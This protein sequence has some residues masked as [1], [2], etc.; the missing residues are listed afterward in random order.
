VAALPLMGCIEGGHFAA[1]T[2]PVAPADLSASGLLEQAGWPPAEKVTEILGGRNNRVYRVETS[3]GPALLKRYFREPTDPRDRL[4]H[5]YGFLQACQQSGV[6]GVPRALA[7]DP[8]GGTALYEFVEGARPAGLGEVELRE[9]GDFIAELNAKRRGPAF[10]A[11]PAAAE[12]CFSLSEHIRSVDLRMDRL[13]SMEEASELDRAAKTWVQAELTPAWR[14]IRGG[15]QRASEMDQVL[16]AGK[17]IVSP[18]DF[19]IHNSLRNRE[20]RLVFLDF[21]YAG[22]DDP[23][24]LVCDFANQP[25]RPLSAEESGAFVRRLLSWMGEEEFWRS[26]FR[27]LAPLHQIKWTCIVLNDF[28][29]LGRSR[30]RFQENGEMEIVRKERQW[31]KAKL[32]LSRLKQGISPF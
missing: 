18:S 21:E 11:L 26:R 15:L 28:L 1:M 31:G 24:K 27:A 2:A 29:P 16:P 4:A 32:M 17:R 20:G 10:C 30:R 6:D 7:W 14:R 8:T 25:D 12:A 19:G 23:A 3:R 9:A 5:E 22:W 13:E